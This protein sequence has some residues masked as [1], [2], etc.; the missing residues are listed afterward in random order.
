MLIEEYAMEANISQNTINLSPPDLYNYIT[1]NPIVHERVMATAQSIV[2]LADTL[3]E[4]MI[5]LGVNTV[6]NIAFEIDGRL[7]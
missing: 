5:K 3:V 7:D 1:S 6:H 2:P 4:A